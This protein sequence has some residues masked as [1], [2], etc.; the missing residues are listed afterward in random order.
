MRTYYLVIYD[1]SEMGMA[2][3]GLPLAIID[4]DDPV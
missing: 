4:N 1:W 3:N 2:Q